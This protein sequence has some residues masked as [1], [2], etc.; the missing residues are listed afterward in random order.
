MRDEE[1]AECQPKKQQSVGLSSMFNHS[2]SSDNIKRVRHRVRD[3][4]LIAAS[5]RSDQIECGLSLSSTASFFQTS[6]ASRERPAASS[7][8]AR[9]MVSVV[10]CTSEIPSDCSNACKN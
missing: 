3:S 1:R 5:A 4:L 9:A 2:S 10:F 7:D 6:S 8:S